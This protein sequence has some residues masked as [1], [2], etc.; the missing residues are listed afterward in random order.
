MHVGLQD[1]DPSFDFADGVVSTQK[2]GHVRWFED[3]SIE[4]TGQ[5]CSRIQRIGG[6]NFDLARER[7]ILDQP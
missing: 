5:Q 3:G 2:I 4:P 7:R 1:D 6:D